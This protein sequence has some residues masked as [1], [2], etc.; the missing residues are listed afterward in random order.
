ML[1]PWVALHSS[2]PIV[3][4]DELRRQIMDWGLSLDHAYL[5]SNDNPAAV[6]E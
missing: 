6:I 1:H 4:T 3:I 2:L 5:F